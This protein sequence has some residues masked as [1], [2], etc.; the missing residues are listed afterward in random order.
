M[1]P[2]LSKWFTCIGLLTLSFVSCLSCIPAAYTRMVVA[3]QRAVAS[4][5][6]LWPSIALVKARPKEDRGSLATAWAID[7]NHLITAGHFC[8]GVVDNIKLGKANAGVDLIGSDRSGGDV[9]LGTAI[10]IAWH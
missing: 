9:E 2:I 3:E 4:P 8:E 6:K 10:I 1:G 5:T 7:P